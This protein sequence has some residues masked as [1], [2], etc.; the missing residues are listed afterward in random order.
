M[1][2]GNSTRPHWCVLPAVLPYQGPL[3][4][5]EEGGLEDQAL[6]PPSFVPPGSPG[7]EAL[8]APAERLSPGPASLV[9][10]SLRC[11][12]ARACVCA[13]VRW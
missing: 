3:E 7:P 10:E 12:L 8:R 5:V 9:R 11:E 13:C 2:T 1:W 4:S 6:L